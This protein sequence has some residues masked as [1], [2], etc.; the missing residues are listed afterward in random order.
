MVHVMPFK[1]SQERI[2]KDICWFLAHCCPSKMVWPLESTLVVGPRI[3]RWLKCSSFE[4]CMRRATSGVFAPRMA[5]LL[6]EMF[7]I[8]P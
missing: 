7:L 4:I 1:L 2:Q 3:A 5:V 6:Q 8:I